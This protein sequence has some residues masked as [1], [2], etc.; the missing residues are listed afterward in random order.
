MARLKL[1]R[2]CTRQAMIIDAA[3]REP[4]TRRRN[5]RS[6]TLPRSPLGARETLMESF[7]AFLPGLRALRTI[8]QLPNCSRPRLMTEFRP[9]L[10]CF[11]KSYRRRGMRNKMETPARH[12][13]PLKR[14]PAL[15]DTC[16][17]R[18]FSSAFHLETLGPVKSS[19]S[20]CL[21]FLGV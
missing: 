17:R 8:F 4:E 18:T 11:C 15:V 1:L 6:L 16:S 14:F 7:A 3:I 21:A 20:H 9:G 19:S 2:Y 13:T 12:G 5:S 10:H